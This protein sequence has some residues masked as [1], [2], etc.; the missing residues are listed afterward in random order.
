MAFPDDFLYELRARNPI[1]DVAS[2]YVNLKRAGHNFKGLCPF[3]AEKTPSFTVY[4]DSSSF[5]CFGCG[6]GGDVITFIKRIENL[7]YPEAVR[8]LAGRAGMTVPEDKAQSGLADA[9]MRIREINREAGRFFYKMLHTQKG[10]AAMEYAKNRGLSEEIIKKFAIGFAPDSWDELYN[11]LKS[12]NYRDEDIEAA[13]LVRKNRY[14]R[15]NDR[16]RNRLMFPIVDLQ[17]NVIGFGGRDL[18]G[19][20]N[21][22]Y[23]NTSDTLI[24]K[25]T[26]NL[27]AL[28]IAKNSKSDFMLLCEGYM[29]AIAMHRAGFDNAV[30]SCGTALTEEQVQLLARYTNSVTIVYDADAAGQKAVRRAIPLIK[31]TGISIK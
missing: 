27:Y 2:G 17:G 9:K 13:D 12:K 5:F 8:F 24:Y 28:N 4:P 1:E 22:K 18:T 10:A 23:I 11:Y 29:D 19:Q 21:A 31:R 7:D 16:Y 25:K 14:G 26:N 6:A 3:H 30:A 15:F 20:S